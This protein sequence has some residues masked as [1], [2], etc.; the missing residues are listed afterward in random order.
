[1][2]TI[3][4]DRRLAGTDQRPA[5]SKTEVQILPVPPHPLTSIVFDVYIHISISLDEKLRR[6]QHRAHSEPGLSGRTNTALETL[7]DTR[8]CRGSAKAAIEI[9]EIGFS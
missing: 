6:S 5:K 7:H 1:M 9:A 3:Q 8:I 4:R 2:K